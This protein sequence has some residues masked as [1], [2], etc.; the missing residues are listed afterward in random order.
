MISDLSKS[1]GA[2]LPTK[3]GVAKVSSLTDIYNKLSKIVNIDSVNPNPVWKRMDLNKLDDM[4][5]ST[6][7]EQLLTALT[8]ILS[9]AG[10][11][12]PRVT[13]ENIIKNYTRMVG[14]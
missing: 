13:A 11:K 6:D 5:K 2:V 4:V 1:S 9:R 10:N 8:N 12:N 3:V 14:K 7:R